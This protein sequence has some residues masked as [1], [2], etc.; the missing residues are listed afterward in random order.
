MAITVSI[1]EES[2]GT[3][4]SL[5]ELL[6]RAPGLRSVGA[7]ANGELA[8]REIVVEKPDVT[9]RDVN[10]P[11]MSGIVKSTTSGQAEGFPR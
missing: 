2:R 6:G 4:E 1:V 8:L 7:H 11:G 9:L 5:V 3:R 10:L